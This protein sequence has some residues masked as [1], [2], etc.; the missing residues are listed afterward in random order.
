M[1]LSFG[2]LG[3]P[4]APRDTPSDS[5]HTSSWIFATLSS[6]LQVHVLS[7]TGCCCS[8]PRALQQAA[9]VLRSML[10]RCPVSPR[11]MLPSLCVS[12]ILVRVGVVSWERPPPFSIFC[13][14]GPLF[15]LAL[16]LWPDAAHECFARLVDRGW[17]MFIIFCVCSR[18]LPGFPCG[19]T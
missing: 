3:E 2:S 15:P 13:P 9:V 4:F 10:L 19:S 7:V 18:S 6:A 14:R 5:G 16:I 12:G 11:C 1:I 17:R 8:C